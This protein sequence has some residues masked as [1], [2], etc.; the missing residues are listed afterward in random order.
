MHGEIQGVGR[1]WVDP[2]SVP[3]ESA[4]HTE[5]TADER[6][7]IERC[8]R[9]LGEH[10]GM[11]LDQW[12]HNFSGNVHPEKELLIYEAMSAAY[13][14]ELKLR[15]KTKFQER[16]LLY[17]AVL[18]ASVSADASVDKVLAIRPELKALPNLRR[19]V[20]AYRDEIDKRG[21]ALTAAH[22][23]VVRRMKAMSEEGGG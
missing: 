10:D 8:W 15:G 3:L 18:T 2:N 17:L 16:R 20:G 1:V 12:F 5:L 4:T 21:D 7:R 22:A 9:I 6:L 11:S 19:A 14:R 13:K 23:E